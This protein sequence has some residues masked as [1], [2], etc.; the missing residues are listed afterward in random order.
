MFLP[1]I[2]YNIKTAGTK[3]LSNAYYPNYAGL[4]FGSTDTFVYY[5]DMNG[6]HRV[7]IYTKEDSVIIPCRIYFFDIYKDSLVYYSL[8][9]DYGYPRIADI[10]TGAIIYESSELMKGFFMQSKDSLLLVKER[11]DGLQIYDIKTGEKS[12]LDAAPYEIAVWAES[13][14]CIDFNPS[15]SRQI[16]FSAAES[17][18][19]G[20]IHDGFELWILEKF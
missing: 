5:S 12:K 3:T 13:G 15:D 14:N 20:F 9:Y 7:N 18:W 6:L 16:I 10:S 19:E 4:Q 1:L 8:V 11:K 17:S 2:L